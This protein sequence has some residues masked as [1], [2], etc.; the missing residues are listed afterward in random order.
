MKSKDYNIV[1]LLIKLWFYIDQPR[2]SKFIGLIFLMVLASLSEV[3]SIGA[4]IPFLGLLISPEQF[5][6]FININKIFDTSLLLKDSNQL[7]LIITALFSILI[8]IAAAIR[9]LMLKK[10]LHFSFL[11]GADLSEK[12]FANSLYQEYKVHLSLNSSE[13]IDAVTVKVNTIIHNIVYPCLVIASSFFILLFIII[14]LLFINPIVL[15]IIFGGFGLIYLLLIILSKKKTIERSEKIS[16]QS[17]NIVK[18]L[19]EGLGGIRDILIDGSQSEY[20]KSFTKANLELRLA[21]GEVVFVN[22]APRHV[23]EALAIIFVSILAYN[24]L[25]FSDDVSTIIPVLG[26]FA[27]AGQRILPVMQQSYNGWSNI[28]SAQASLRDVLRYLEQPTPLLYKSNSLKK[29]EFS[30]SILLKK[31]SFAYSSELPLF[32]NQLTLK[33]EKG[34]RIGVIGES[35]SGKSTLL[36]LLMGLIDPTSGHIEID[37]RVINESNKRLWQKKIAHV[38]QSIFLSDATIAENIAFGVPKEKI[39]WSK[40]INA[41]M[42]AKIHDTII[43]LDLG[44]ETLVGE[45]GIR[46]SGGQRQRIAIARALY[47]DA[48]LIIFDEATSALDIKTED[49]IIA[50]IEK[51]SNEITIIIVAHRLTT[52]K[53]CT[54]IIELS[55]GT[56]KRMGSFDKIV[57]KAP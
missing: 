41:A 33:I 28:R 21:Q 9:L 11:I 6:D 12:I 35:G 56:I 49:G 54:K 18:F 15:I 24:F 29:I 13:I 19:Q 36:D 27:L 5:I 7:T 26:A 17:I 42:Q 14:S 31:V 16:T 44:Y 47:K 20:I 3:L 25:S 4:I 30:Q 57:G 43:E 39:D 53:N 8:F 51:L 55:N 22:Q 40:L 32:F 38:P 1:T 52:L 37:G 48:N 46:L 23:I 34:S 10:L 45:Q 50:E 2:K